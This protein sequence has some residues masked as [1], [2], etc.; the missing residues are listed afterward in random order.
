MTILCILLIIVLMFRLNTKGKAR[1]ERLRNEKRIAQAQERRQ[2]IA[3]GKAL[4]PEQIEQQ[5]KEALERQY[6]KELEKQG[7]SDEL[8]TTIIPTIMNDGK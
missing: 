8:I 6:R 2:A 3:Q 7:Y 4:T 5:K 1:L